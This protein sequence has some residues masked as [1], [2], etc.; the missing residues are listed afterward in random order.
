MRFI[1]VPAQLDRSDLRFVLESERDWDL[2]LSLCD[3]IARDE[4]QWQTLTELALSNQ[5]YRAESGH[6]PTER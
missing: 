2:A 4:T 6:A 5:L 1:P 3:S